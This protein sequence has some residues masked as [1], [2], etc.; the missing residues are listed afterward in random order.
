MG[1][2]PNAHPQTDVTFTSITMTGG[3]RHERD[4]PVLVP[5]RKNFGSRCRSRSEKNLL[6]VLVKKILVPE[7]L[8][9]SLGVM[10]KL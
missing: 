6:P 3:I 9:P 10:R 4:Q 7:P 1:T 2:S 5:A 8:C